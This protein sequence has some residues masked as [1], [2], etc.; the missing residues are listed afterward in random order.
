M[1]EDINVQRKAN[2]SL[3]GV[4]EVDRLRARA[5]P[6]L[7]R[8]LGGA[9][10]RARRRRAVLDP[11]D[12]G[13]RDRR[14]LRARRP[15][16]ARRPTTRSST[17]EE[18]GYYRETNRA[19]GLEGGMTTG[20]PL[21]VRA[22]MKPLP[23]LTK[24]LRSVDIA[25]HEPAEALRERTDSCTVPAAGVVG[26]AMV[27]FVLADAY[28]R[29]F[30]GD[31]I[32]DV[33]EAVDALRA[34]GSGG[35]ALDGAR[36]RLHRL[37]GG[38]QDD[39]RA[40]GGR[41]AG[42]PRRRHRRRA[43]RAARRAD[44][45]VLRPRGRGGV[46]RARGGGRLRA[47][48][49]RRRRRRRRLARRRRA[50]VRA[51][52]R[53]ARAPHRRAWSRSTARPRGQRASRRAR[54]LARDR[55]AFVA[56]PRRADADL[57]GA[58][59]RGRC[60]PATP[61]IGAPALP[62]RWPRLPAG[63]R[64]LWAHAASGDY[65]VYIGERAR[66]RE[67]PARFAASPT[68]TSAPLYGERVEARAA[69]TI[70]PGEAAQDAAP[71]RAACGRA[72]ARRGVTRADTLVALGGGVVGDLAG[73][74][75]ATYQR[76]VAVVQVPT[77]LVAQ[78]DSAYGGKTGVDL[79][80]AK[81]YV[82]AYH[83]P[84]A[85]LA[86]PAT[87]ATLPR[88][89]ARRRL[90]RGGQDRADRR[91]AAVGAR[92]AAGG[93]S[94]SP[95]SCSPARA[96]SWPSSPPTS[97]TAAAPGRSTSAT[98]SATRS[99]RRPATPATAT[100]RRSGS[101]CWPR[102]GSPGRTQLREQVARAADRRGL[103]SRSTASTPTRSSRRPRAT[104]SASA[105]DVPFVLVDA[106]GR[107]DVRATPIAEHDVLPPC[108]ELARHREHD[109][110]ASRSCTASTSTSSAA[111]RDAL[112]RADVRAARAPHR[113]VRRELG[114]SVA[115]L[116][117]QPRARVRRA[118]APARGPGRRAHPQPRGV[119]AL[120]VGDPRRAGDR[121]RCRRSRCTCPTSSRARSG[122]ASR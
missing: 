34:S 79:P 111:G 74:C 46:P 93:R 50:R 19:G 54:P 51:R 40:G 110:T 118:P 38:R 99:R 18:R 113:R 65:P 101:G 21:V 16:R 88:R 17:T 120:R 94:P 31:H 12:Q 3:G 106:P 37:H 115:L 29:K 71:R 9:P 76:G 96:R 22:A 80:E 47:A 32:D 108:E 102:C 67:R 57:R 56:L 62:A 114:L 69:L 103:P 68:S 73:F 7:A 116:P 15:S 89:R 53:R 24:P 105:T 1:V 60:R 90:R 5:G 27:A 121:R 26:E 61:A 63:T 8:H 36:P 104:R 87:L 81:N 33:V 41:R 20:E 30:G 10:R 109:A 48:G 6:R 95:T 44:R 59:R 98:R 75:A 25:T 85:V 117:D 45:G 77:T 100:A 42:A 43:R 83:Q 112:R 58:G 4:F 107:R 14:R 13:R 84:S 23:T 122:G 66:G 91:R 78:V 72:L 92:R 64:L 82:G 119:D 2:E 39:G 86:D 49:R 52:A 35:R 28:R 97:A 55:D 11:G 70:A